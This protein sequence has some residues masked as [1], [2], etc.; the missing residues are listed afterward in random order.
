MVVDRSRRVFTHTIFSRLVDHL[1]P[2][3]LL[4][5]NDTRVIPARCVG[6]RRTGGKVKILLVEKVSQT[7]WKV[8]IDTPRRIKPG[9]LIIFPKGVRLE[10]KGRDMDGNW[11]VEFNRDILPLLEEIGQVPLPH[12]I[13]RPQGPTPEDRIRY[14]TVYAAK[15]GAIAAPTAGFHFTHRLLKRLADKGIKHTFV[16]LHVGVGTFKP[17][18]TEDLTRHKVQPE[19]YEIPPQTISEIQRVKG[20]AGRVIATGTSVLRALEGFYRTLQPS[21]R[22]DLYIMPPFDFM[23]VDALITNLHLPK[24]PNLLIVYALLGK[25]FT[26]HA[27]E[28]AK[29][30]GYRF[31][32]YGDAMLIL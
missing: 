24:S 14:Q 27:Y 29:R 19:Y 30:L 5:F 23:V 32:S 25:E 22:T 28:E 15:D 12:Y 2:G 6:H 4:V 11:D 3:D 10:V 13:K 21:G 20:S 8:L 1:N 17:I 7:G 31:Y 18:K 9:E 16:T 26:I